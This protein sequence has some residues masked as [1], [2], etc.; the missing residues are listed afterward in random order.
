MIPTRN[1]YALLIEAALEA[2]LIQEDVDH[3]V[4]VVDD[5]STDGTSEQ[6]AARD[7]PRLR[8]VR[9]D[10][11][12][13]VARARN[14]GIAAAQGRWVAFLDDDDIW[15][16]RKL[17]MQI[18]AASSGG[19]GFAYGGSIW[20]DEQKHFLYGHTPPDPTTLRQQLLHRNVMWSGCSNVVVQSDLVRRVGG[21]DE[22]LFQLADWDLWLRLSREAPAACC[23]D[24]VVGY[25]R[26]GENMVLV[27]R[28]DVFREFDY[29]VE[30]HR[31]SS[32]ELAIDF[33]Q[34]WFARWVA[35]GHMRAGRRSPA[36]RAYLRGARRGRSLG[37]LLRAG[38]VPLGERFQNVAQRAFA[39]IP[40]WLP[41]G[42][43][44]AVEPDWLRL[45]R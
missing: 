33:D 4:V 16:P 45:Y 22:A 30:K 18:D 2:A 29:L 20:V 5:G 19:A 35:A 13:G 26:H 7:E 39:A 6:L 37:N 32:R 38:A 12:R 43:R 28:E 17:R 44:T 23:S 9:H 24:V 11:A 31:D 40:G 34:A 27:E 8:L 14:A 42:E 3:E 36:A 21:F 1:R 41:S 15:S 10:E 25:A